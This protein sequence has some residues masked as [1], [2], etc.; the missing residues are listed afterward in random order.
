MEPDISLIK[1]IC[2]EA[3]DTI[4]YYYQNQNSFTLNHKE[5]LSP[6][7]EADITAS[8]II[9]SRLQVAYPD[10]PAISEEEYVPTYEERKSWPLLWLIDPL[11]GTKEFIKKTDEF[12]INIA[13]IHDGIPI[14]GFIMVPCTGVFYYAIK[15]KGAY[16]LDGTEPMKINTRM[17]GENEPTIIVVSRSHP[18]DLTLKEIEKVHDRSLITAGSALKFLL[19]AEGKAHYYPRMVSIM[20]WDTAAAQIILEEAGGRLVDAFD[21]KPLVYNKPSMRSPFFKAYSTQ[22]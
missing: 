15:G 5:D 10:I 3:A 19:I 20:E 17:Q 18:D 9:T 16:V 1:Q 2:D 8:R 14:A 6:F 12:T 13:L 21:E 7:S 4:M 11:D 22:N